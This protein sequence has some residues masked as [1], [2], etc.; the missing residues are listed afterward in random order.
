MNLLIKLHKLSLKGRTL[1]HIRAKSED[2]YWAGE[3]SWNPN[4][5]LASWNRNRL[6]V[7]DKQL[8]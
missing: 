7:L 5:N 1:Q 8:Q 3:K 4:W 2:M 6:F